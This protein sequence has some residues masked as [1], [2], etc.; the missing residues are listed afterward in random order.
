MKKLFAAVMMMFGAVLLSD[1]Q[2]VISNESLTH[3]GT[4][5][6]VTFDI[7]TDVKDLPSNR[8]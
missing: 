5:V 2:T 6:T 8:K 1:A 3:D 4:N 7:D